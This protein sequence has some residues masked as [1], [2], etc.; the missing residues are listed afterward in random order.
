MSE[1]SMIF[2]AVDDGRG[3]LRPFPRLPRGYS[4]DGVRYLTPSQCS[5]RFGKSEDDWRAEWIGVWGEYLDPVEA[6]PQIATVAARAGDDI[7]R[8]VRFPHLDDQQ[9]AYVK[10]QCDRRKIHPTEIWVKLRNNPETGK[11]EPVIITTIGVFRRIA[12]AT[13]FRGPESSAEFCGED[14]QFMPGPWP[15]NKGFPHAARVHVK[16]KDMEGGFEGVAYFEL[17][18][19][20]VKGPDGKPQL[21]ECWAAAN[22][23]PQLAKCATVA[24]YRAAYTELSSLYTLDEMRSGRSSPENDRKADKAQIAELPD[25]TDVVNA[26]R[27]A[28][29]QNASGP[30]PDDPRMAIKYV[31]ETTP[32]IEGLRSALMRTDS[33][34]NLV[35]AQA[36][37]DKCRLKWP[38]TFS[39]APAGFCALVMRTA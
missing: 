34:N 28:S 39:I 21:S 27:Q 22:G 2:E 8:V 31:D 19:Q 6:D 38:R 13:G 3:S 36:F 16:R 29:P 32:D 30:L 20:Y 25:D 24:A 15:P 4:A 17:C 9:W 11:I 35:E 1:L 18:A 10:V 33:I 12:E 14:C 5:Q 23:A 7:V 26:L 37:I